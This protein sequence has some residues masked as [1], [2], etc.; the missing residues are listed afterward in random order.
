M[1]QQ[2]AC[3]LFPTQYLTLDSFAACA[4]V[5]W[6]MFP[7]ELGREPEALDLVAKLAGKSD[8]AADAVMYLWKCTSDGR[9]F[10]CANGPYRTDAEMG[11]LL[12]GF[13][14][15]NFKA[16]DEATPEQHLAEIVDTLAHWQVSWCGR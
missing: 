12:G 10:A 14:F 6:L 8:D 3:Q 11:E 13:S 9:V 1:H 16:W 15:S 7:S 5:Q 2:F 4:M